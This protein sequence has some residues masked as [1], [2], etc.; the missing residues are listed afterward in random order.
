MHNRGSDRTRDQDNLN[1]NWKRFNMDEQLVQSTVTWEKGEKQPNTFKDPLFAIVFLTHVGT[2][3]TLAALYGM[4]GVKDY[5]DRTTGEDININED[6]DYTDAFYSAGALG[7]LS[8]VLSSVMLSVLTISASFLIKLSLL[9]SV[10]MSAF[11]VF[12]SIWYY[13][14]IAS[15]DTDGSWIGVATGSLFFLISVCYARS[16]WSRIPFATANLVTA[17]TA[18]K[19]NFGIILIS[20]FFIIVAFIWSGIW[21]LALIGVL[22]KTQVCDAQTNECQSNF[23]YSFPFLLSYY[24]THQVITNVVHVTIAGVVG[25][26]WFAPEEASSCLSSAVRESFLRSATYSFGSI[27]FGSLLVALVQALRALV[28]NSRER[29]DGNGFLLCI[30][31]CLLSCLQGIIEYFNKWAFVYVG[32][33]GYSYIEAGKNVTTLFKARG[34]ELLVTDQLIGNALSL[35]SFIV[36]LLMSAVGVLLEYKMNW[37]ATV[38]VSGDI[39]QIISGSLGFFFGLIFCSITLNV[40]DYGVNATIVLFLEAPADF[41]GNH[42]KLA[43][44]M[45]SAWTEVCPNRDFMNQNW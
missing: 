4:D 41:K 12:A 25:T 16:V 17:V 38:G 22:N 29:S 24:W 15:W 8:F 11:T 14:T 26:W 37:I 42:P 20:Y 10:V 35:V 9:F 40:I 6:V 30:A 33:Y 45:F 2:I 34:V 3:T 13:S 5:A 21:L 44:E 7:C 31:Q 23:I 43:E 39:A 32:L 19:R 18:L 28:D 27:C 36:G 1:S